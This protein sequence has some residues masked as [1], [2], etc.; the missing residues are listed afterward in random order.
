VIISKEG[1]LAG[2]NISV[3]PCNGQ[4]GISSSERMYRPLPEYPR[5][6]PPPVVM[7]L[8]F[9]AGAHHRGR[10]SR[11]MSSHE[12]AQVYRYCS[13]FATSSSPPQAPECHL[14]SLPG[15]PWYFLFHGRNRTT[16]ENSLLLPPTCS[17]SPS[18]MI[19]KRVRQVNA[20]LLCVTSTVRPSLSS[21]VVMPPSPSTDGL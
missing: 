1:H 8:Y 19:M 2:P 17:A 11:S 13:P 21:E 15:T 14:P 7:V 5:F 6:Y 16:K 9:H 10:Q 3:T 12:M 20:E 4:V 18:R